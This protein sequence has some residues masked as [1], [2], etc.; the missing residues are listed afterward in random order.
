MVLNKQE[1]AITVFSLLLFWGLPVFSAD[2]NMKPVI[3][4]V[5]LY[6]SDG[7][8]SSDIKSSGLFPDRIAGTVQSGLPA[9][10]ELFFS[11]DSR[12]DSSVKRGFFSFELRYDVWDDLYSAE[13]ADTTMFFPSFEALSNT[14]QHLQKIAIVPIRDISLNQ[15][16]SIRFSIAV[17]PLQ[18]SDREKIAGWLDETVRGKTGESWRE[19]VLN[20]NDL[21]QHFF[22]TRKG[23][24]HQ[25]DWFL[26]DFF[27]P[28][29]LPVLEDRNNEE[30]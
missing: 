13:G 3:L 27:K 4:G 11:L 12:N 10:V 7:T 28:G 16:Y 2:Q 14:V 25:S 23:G 19:Q 20:L 18:G 30:E 15:E 21:I 1:L 17:N 29:S 8:I 26:T 5:N 9:V 24:A 22:S 6:V